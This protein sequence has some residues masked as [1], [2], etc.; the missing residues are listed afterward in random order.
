MFQHY[1]LNRKSGTKVHYWGQQAGHPAAAPS[2]AHL[3]ACC[4]SSST[5]ALLPSQPPP[6]LPLALLLLQ[7]CLQRVDVSR[8]ACV[9]R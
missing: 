1:S 3:S 9:A 8:R 6:L 4:A 2:A 5:A 7:P